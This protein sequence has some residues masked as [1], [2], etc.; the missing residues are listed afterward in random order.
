MKNNVNHVKADDFLSKPFSSKI[1]IEKI[2]S[3]VKPVVPIDNHSVQVIQ[4]DTDSIQFGNEDIDLVFES[5]IL[6][7]SFILLNR[8]FVND[9]LAISR[10]FIMDGIKKQQQSLLLSFDMSIAQFNNACPLNVTE[11]SFL[12]F[13]DASN[14]TQI[15]SKPWRNIDYIYDT[16]FE[17]AQKNHF[18]V[19]LLIHLVMVLHFL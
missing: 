19:L 15:N 11:Q 10:E 8:H 16:L 12:T 4:K 1:M 3:Y 14:W 7:Q 2:K 9:K 6:P 13:L 18:N 5:P 17:C